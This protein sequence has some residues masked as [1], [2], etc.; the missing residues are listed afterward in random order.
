MCYIRIFI[1]SINFWLPLL[2]PSSTLV[3]F[4]PAF[5]RYF[6]AFI[7]NAGQKFYSTLPSLPD[8]TLCSCPASVRHLLILSQ[9]LY[10]KAISNILSKNMY[11]KLHIY[12]DHQYNLY[13]SLSKMFKTT[14]SRVCRQPAPPCRLLRACWQRC[15]RETPPPSGSVWAS[16]ARIS[17]AQLLLQAGWMTVEPSCPKMEATCWP[18]LPRCKQETFMTSRKRLILHSRPMKISEQIHGR[19]SWRFETFFHPPWS[20]SWSTSRKWSQIPSWRPEGK[21]LRS[22]TQLSTRWFRQLDAFDMNCWLLL[23]SL[24]TYLSKIV[25]ILWSSCWTP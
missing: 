21:D 16:R 7:E 3:M 24:M 11:D 18:C 12:I 19:S 1:R 5:Q 6:L 17:W 13:M 10:L 22:F 4:C 8:K 9:K 14:V 2:N 25:R 15:G 23:E 20:V